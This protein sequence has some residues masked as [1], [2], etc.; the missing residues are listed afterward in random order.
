M[1][2]IPVV[3]PSAPVV[4]PSTLMMPTSAPSIS[5]EVASGSCI[6]ARYSAA[7]KKVAEYAHFHGG[8]AAAKHFKVHHKNVQRWL[9]EE[10]DTMKNPH[11]AKWCNKKGQGRK[12]S[13]P[14]KI[15][16]QLLQWVL[17]LREEKQ[18]PVS[19]HKIKVKALSLIKLVQPDFRASDG[20]VKAL[21]RLFI[22]QRLPLL[23]SVLVN[24]FRRPGKIY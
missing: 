12:I 14:V 20:W 22:E 7:Q 1:T 21:V 5:T 24:K 3:P 15:E 4:S 16:K 19:R 9:K 6:R 8:R 10:L 2:P 11:R 23:P 18:L 13:Y 17:E